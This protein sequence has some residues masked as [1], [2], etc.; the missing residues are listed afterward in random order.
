MRIIVQKKDLEEAIG[1]LGEGLAH[2]EWMES[3]G[4][5]T[6][7]ETVPLNTLR[8]A[9]FILNRI[10]RGEPFREPPFEM[11]EEEGEE[12]YEDDE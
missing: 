3:V 7:E 11:D 12:E 2:F 10:L 8:A 1:V 6:R 5:T 9:D 4:A